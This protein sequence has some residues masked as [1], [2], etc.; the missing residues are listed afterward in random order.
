MVDVTSAAHYVEIVSAVL[1]LA[2]GYLSYQ[3]IGTAGARRDRAIALGLGVVLLGFA[4][5]SLMLVYFD[6]HVATPTPTH[7]CL[8][9]LMSAVA[10]I[11]IVRSGR[12]W[13]DGQDKWRHVRFFVSLL[14]TFGAGVLAANLQ[15]LLDNAQGARSG[16]EPGWIAAFDGIVLVCVVLSIVAYLWD[17]AHRVSNPEPAAKDRPKPP[18]MTRRPPVDTTA[19]DG[20]AVP[21]STT[22]TPRGARR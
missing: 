8:Y 21:K 15:L 14:C 22:W 12:R 16:A 6:M 20:F 5:Y 2:G 18:T 11:Q 10:L 1:G 4:G 9:G 3:L 7:T 19:I 17:L 13:N